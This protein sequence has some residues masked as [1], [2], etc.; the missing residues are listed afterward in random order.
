MCIRDSF[1]DGTGVI[2]ERWLPQLRYVLEEF[3][4]SARNGSRNNLDFWNQVGHAE[5]LPYSGTFLSGWITAFTFFDEFGDVV[6]GNTDPVTGEVHAF[7]TM[8]P[9]D[10][11]EGILSCPIL[12]DDIDG[13]L[14]NSTLFVGQMAYETEPDGDASVGNAAL[15][16]LLAETTEV[17]SPRT[18]WAIV[19]HTQETVEKE[20]PTVDEFAE[21]LSLIHI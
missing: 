21:D 9:A 15:D 18:D 11:N 3:V 2:T 8:K 17:V 7:G 10:V 16:P 4:E 5:T 19:V 14:Y 12:I 6:V 13:Q 1:D 20:R